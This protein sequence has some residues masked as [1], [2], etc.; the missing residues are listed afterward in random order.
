L[1]IF[2]YNPP[3]LDSM[4]RRAEKIGDV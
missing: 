2:V 4:Y 3:R 1:Y